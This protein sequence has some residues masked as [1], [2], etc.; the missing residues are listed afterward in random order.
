[1]GPLLDNSV[2]TQPEYS[3]WFNDAEWGVENYGTEPTIEV[4]IEPQEHASGKDPQLQRA[5]SEALRLM[6][7]RPPERPDF[8][9]R[10]RLAHPAL[11]E[12]ARRG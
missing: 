7:E 1:E 8:G 3:F 9:D 11:P 10:P 4:E 2:T 6:D 12:R 5:I